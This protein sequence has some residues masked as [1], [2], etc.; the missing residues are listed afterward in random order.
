MIIDPLK[1][2]RRIIYARFE[3]YF[4]YLNIIFWPLLSGLL[5]PENMHKGLIEVI[6]FITI[7][8]TIISIHMI[9][10]CKKEIKLIFKGF[11][12]T[13][14]KERVK[15]QSLELYKLT[16][17]I[18]S[19]KSIIKVINKV[20]QVNEK[21]KYD[22]APIYPDKNGFIRQWEADQFDPTIING[23]W[24]EDFSR[25][26]IKCPTQLRDKIILMQNSL[27]DIFEEILNSNDYK[28][29]HG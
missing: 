5:K 2:Q 3:M 27:P 12:D 24:A 9:L 28:E 26:E 8:M 20:K 14:F 25:Y 22:L 17:N 6:Y 16:E 1:K 13:E 15:T 21:I 4:W 18:Q 23:F 11:D 19:A 29:I 10:Q 7:V